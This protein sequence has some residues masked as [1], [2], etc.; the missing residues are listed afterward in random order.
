MNILFL[1][2]F[3]EQINSKLKNFIE[4][5]P[6]YPQ[7]FYFEWAQQKDCNKKTFYNFITQ[8]FSENFL[9]SIIYMSHSPYP[10]VQIL[11]N[12]FEKYNEEN[13]H[14]NSFS[15]MVTKSNFMEILKEQILRQFSQKEI[16]DMERYHKSLSRGTGVN[17]G[18]I[19]ED[20][21]KNSFL[22][23]FDVFFRDKNVCL[24][25]FLIY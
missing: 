20:E 9:Q 3:E 10:E 2:L 18:W 1:V 4:Y 25:L 5:E 24:I 19:L 21:R 8:N 22:E 15:S 13:Y 16:S 17:V 23:V 6:D 7:G 11:V 12:Y 14:T